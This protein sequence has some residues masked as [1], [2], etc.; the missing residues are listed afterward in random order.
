MKKHYILIVFFAFAF[1]FSQHGVAQSTP[2]NN[3]ALNI[4]GLSIYP[5]P[6][7]QGRLYIS[8]TTTQNMTNEVDIFPVL[9]QHL[10]ATTLFGK[11]LNIQKLNAGVYIL[12]ITENN[13][14]A[15]RKLV[16]K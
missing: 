12:K 10:F 8:I 16:I 7:T 14:S 1:M 5:N 4:E 11:E 6:V 3:A 13:I 2:Q 15:T 9:G